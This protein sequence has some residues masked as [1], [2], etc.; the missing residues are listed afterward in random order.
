MTA[1]QT[2]STDNPWK[3]SVVHRGVFLHEVYRL[4]LTASGYQIS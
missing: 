4:I 2:S 1:C 3:H